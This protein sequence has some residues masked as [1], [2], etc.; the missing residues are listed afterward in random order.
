TEGAT[1]AIGDQAPLLDSAKEAP[2][3]GEVPAQ[4]TAQPAQPA[5]PP[6]TSDGD[7]QRLEQ[8]VEFQSLRSEEGR[9]I[10][11]YDDRRRERREGSEVLREIGDRVVIQFGNQTVVRSDDRGRIG[12]DSSEVYYEELPRGRTR[13]TVV[14]PN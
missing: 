13:E 14:R 11:R 3:A 1:E 4:E 10:E 9:R 6:P 7:A 8:P 5:A 2:P 12:R